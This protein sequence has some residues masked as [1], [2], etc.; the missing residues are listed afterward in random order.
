MDGGAKAGGGGKGMV[1]WLL[2][3]LWLGVAVMAPCRRCELQSLLG[4]AVAAMAFMAFMTW[5]MGSGVEGMAEAAETFR[6]KVRTIFAELVGDRA[7]NLGRNGAQGMISA[8][9]ADDLGVE[10]AADR[11]IRSDGELL[12]RSQAMAGRPE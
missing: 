5:N 8:A 7:P 1:L 6:R 4:L 2:W 11:T 10:H 12:D 3:R 9:L